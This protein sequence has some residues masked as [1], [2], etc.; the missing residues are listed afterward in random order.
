MGSL[1]AET[2][3]AEGAGVDGSTRSSEDSGIGG[4][5]GLPLGLGADH[6]RVGLQKEK[7]KSKLVQAA[8]EESNTDGRRR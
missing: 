6:W 2:V 8:E 3:C 5:F 4:N 7:R 1:S